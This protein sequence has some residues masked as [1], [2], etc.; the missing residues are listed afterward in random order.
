MT[1]CNV[2]NGECGYECCLTI[3]RVTLGFYHVLQPAHDPKFCSLIGYATRYLILDRRWVKWQG[4]KSSCILQPQSY[5]RIY[6]K[7]LIDLNKYCLPSDEGLTFESLL[8][9]TVLPCVAT[10]VICLT[11]SRSTLIHC[12]SLLEAQ[13]TLICLRSWSSSKYKRALLAL[14]TQPPPWYTDIRLANLWVW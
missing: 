13:H 14:A 6:D 11:L 4:L 8:T 3:S 1:I 12:R 10:A 9:I 5:C 2:L 7:P